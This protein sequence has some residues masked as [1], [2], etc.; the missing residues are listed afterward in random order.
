MTKSPLICLDSARIESIS[1]S[2][3]VV[4]EDPMKLFVGNLPCIWFVS[5]KIAAVSPEINA[6]A[7]SLRSVVAGSFAASSSANRASVATLA[8]AA[9]SV[10]L[11]SVLVD[12]V[13]TSV[14]FAHRFVFVISPSLSIP[15]AL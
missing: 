7:V 3:S 15:N 12:V 11:I 9:L 8:S 10:P 4:T 14:V 13:S 2:L 1:P 6:K 5:T